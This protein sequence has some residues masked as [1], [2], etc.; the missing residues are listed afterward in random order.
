MLYAPH[1]YSRLVLVS[2]QRLKLVKTLFINRDHVTPCQEMVGLCSMCYLSTGESL[3]SVC[4]SKYGT[5]ERE[6][7]ERK[8]IQKL[9]E[10]ADGKQK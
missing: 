7:R 9:P 10:R 4:A 2:I 1:A 5:E 3:T 8:S 6:K